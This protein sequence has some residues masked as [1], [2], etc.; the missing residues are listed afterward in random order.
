MKNFKL[1]LLLLIATLL[2]TSCKNEEKEDAEFAID[3]YSKYLDSISAIPTIEVAENWEEIE[4]KLNKARARAEV[5]VE[6][7][8]EKDTLHL[9]LNKVS[10]KY[11]SYKK[12]IQLEKEKLDAVNQ[13]SPIR[14]ELFE[15]LSIGNN[16]KFEWVTKDNILSVYETF[17]TN[18]QKN[19]DT[20]SRED[21]D[22]IKLLYEALDTR[23]N[24]VEKEGLSSEDNRKIAV[25]KIK[26]APMFTFNRMDAKSGENAEAKK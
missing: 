16:M 9:N 7:I 1:L 24:T 19:K 18:S 14:K 15:K 23:K 2:V 20:Y 11:D 26:F 25:L 17:V 4:S 21:W 5:Y 8:S 6:K 3:E 22:E 12:K 10:K 13:T